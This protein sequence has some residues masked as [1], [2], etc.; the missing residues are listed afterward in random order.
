MTEE[1]PDGVSTVVNESQ[2]SDEI[3]L[4]PSNLFD[5]KIDRQIVDPRNITERRRGLTVEANSKLRVI[6]QLESGRMDYM[7]MKV[8]RYL[9]DGSE[10]ADPGDLAIFL[11]LDGFAQGGFESIYDPV[12]GGSVTGIK[13]SIISELQLPEQMGMFYLTVDQTNT[14][15]VVFRGRAGY[16]HRFRLEVMNTNASSSIFIEF[17]EIARARRTAK[18]GGANTTGSNLSQMGY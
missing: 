1:L 2:D 11:Q 7:I 12:L 8:N 13:L 18:E 5:Q 17:V 9:A 10:G 6:D 3:M 16:A 4:L 14:K 15:V